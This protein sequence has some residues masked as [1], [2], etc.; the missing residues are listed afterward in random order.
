MQTTDD[1]GAALD[2]NSHDIADL[3]AT[4]QGYGDSFG[5]SFYSL[6]S[7]RINEIAAYAT[8]KAS[9]N[10]TAAT[11]ATNALATN[12]TNLA[13][14]VHQ[15]NK[16]IA[17]NTVASTGL[18]D[19]LTTDN[20][21]VT[22]FVDAQAS[23]DTGAVADLVTAAEQFRHTATVLAAAA[24][25]LDPDQFPGTATGTA[26]NLRAGVTS[27]FT[28]HVQL[29]GL[30]IDELVKG[31][32]DGP[33]QAALDANTMQLSNI[34]TVNF[35]DPAARSFSAL[36]NNYV[37]ELVAAARAKSGS[38]TAPD[39]S[40]V[41]AQVGG[42]FAQQTPLLSASTIGADTQ[43]MV[44]ALSTYVDDA[45]SG[46]QPVTQLRVAA[47]TVPKLASDLSEGIAQFKPTQYLP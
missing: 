29:A 47:G 23:K 46:S 21:A 32:G 15:S 13:T 38:G 30:T 42:F 6:W 18:A 7:T 11:N 10:A 3:L 43:K 39:L 26:A 34:V 8:A 33:E 1:R 27:A 37:A 16:F 36:W 44:D 45:A 9:K 24:A 25:K 12:A 35:G 17:V 41:G 14:L 4:A 2:S 22:A 31:A 28:E 5:S 20:T 19:E 40:G